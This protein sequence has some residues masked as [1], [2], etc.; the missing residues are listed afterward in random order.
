MQNKR[1]KKKEGEINCGDEWMCLKMNIKKKNNDFTGEQSRQT[2]S[3]IT[4]EDVKK[5]L[6]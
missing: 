5:M 4:W 2:E 1:Q 3:G 6:S